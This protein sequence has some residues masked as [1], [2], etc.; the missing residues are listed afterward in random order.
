[1][2]LSVIIIACVI[3]LTAY[4]LDIL[5]AKIKTP[6]VILLLALGLLVH[7]I[8]SWLHIS[9][10]D[11]N[12]F[13]P[14]LGTVGLILIVL[15]GALELKLNSSKKGMIKRSF[16]LAF[17]PMLLLAFG[18]AFVFYYTGQ[19]SFKNCLAN[20]IPL[21]IISSAV[22]IP[23]VRNL[24][25]E[26]REFVIYESSLS[27]ILG[28]LFF[29]FVALNREINVESVEHF[30]LQ[31]LFIILITMIATIGITWMIRKVD[32]HVKH[33]PVLLVIVLIYA[34]SKTMH[35]PGLVF[36]LI[37][38]LFLGN[39]LQ[40]SENKW[41]KKLD[42]V[43]MASKVNQFLE[44]T[45]EATFL[46][47]VLFFILFG[48][49]I[50]W[51]DIINKETILWAAGIV[52]CVYLIRALFLWLLKAPVF[53][54]LFIAPRGLITVLLFYNILP[55]DRIAAVNKSLIIQVV[56]ITAFIMMIGSLFTK[57]KRS[58][59]QVNNK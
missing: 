56:L 37:C 58:E 27:D 47:R 14:V 30:G 48:F 54:L 34:L 46:I 15:E 55:E 12:L 2:T 8:V 26:E 25:S 42:P 59:M 50:E 33:T 19:G 36:V 32:F 35:L 9:V 31:I 43:T 28:V 23:S 10:P 6:S 57:T 40:F 18:V 53:P 20:A 5:S 49:L 11:L 16:I 17:I 41:I 44:I 21:S 7:E 24:P 13:L 39:I 3:L 38:G 29:N 45:I 1:M 52:L 51:S 22:A 4:L